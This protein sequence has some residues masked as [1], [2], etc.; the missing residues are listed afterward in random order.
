MKKTSRLNRKTKFTKDYKEYLDSDT[1]I[2]RREEI[3]YQRGRK[4]ECCGSRKRL[5]VHHKTYI[6]FTREEDYDL[7]VLCLS[8]HKSV[9]K[10]SDNIGDLAMATEI[11]LKRKKPIED[12]TPNSRKNGPVTIFY[13]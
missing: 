12:L 8:C 13:G 1:W 11:I 4:C 10:L 2:K 5:H 9:H 6:R 3:L 7:V